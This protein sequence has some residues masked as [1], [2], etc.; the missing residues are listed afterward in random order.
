MEQYNSGIGHMNKNSTK[1]HAPPG[2]RSNFNIFGG[3]EPAQRTTPNEAQTKRNKSS[4]FDPPDEPSSSRN[5]PVEQGSSIQAP[6]AAT[7]AP[8]APAAPAKSK[9]AEIP[10]NPPPVANATGPGGGR[11]STKVIA[12]P[13]GKSSIN[14]FG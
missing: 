13:G 8:S 11:A 14:L 10:A 12:P 5:P 6:Y 9:P 3:D 4:I 2:G 1:V 7:A